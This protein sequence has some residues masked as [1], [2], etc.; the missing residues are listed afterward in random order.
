MGVTI[1]SFKLGFSG[2]TPDYL[3]PVGALAKA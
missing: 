1:S 3:E 2:P